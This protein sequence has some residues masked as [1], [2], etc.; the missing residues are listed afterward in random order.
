MRL[1][2]LKKP[3]D[4]HLRRKQLEALSR[5][6]RYEA[7]IFSEEIV[8]NDFKDALRFRPEQT[9]HLVDILNEALWM[10]IDY[11]IQC[12]R[13]F[14]PGGGFTPLLVHPPTKKDVAE[15][16]APIEQFFRSDKKRGAE[17]TVTLLVAVDRALKRL[18]I[19]SSQESM[20]K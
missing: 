10:Y 4:L 18:C 5:E 1:S 3:L 2:T 16:F 14:Q 13:D 15:A 9:T 7:G 8:K 11:R 17:T 6:I 19:E 12:P 20:R